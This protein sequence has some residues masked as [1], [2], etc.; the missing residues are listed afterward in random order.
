VVAVPVPLS[1]RRRRC[2]PL[3]SLNAGRSSL[4]FPTMFL[5]LSFVLK[6]EINSP[7]ELNDSVY[8]SFEL[9]L[10]C[11]AIEFLKGFISAKLSVDIPACWSANI[12]SPKRWTHP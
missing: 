2:R 1:R 3:G 5:F 11:R 6:N 4:A 9:S 7:P 10:K 8:F 12:S